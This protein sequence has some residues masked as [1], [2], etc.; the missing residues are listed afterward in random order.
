MS[1]PV[2]VKVH[3][4]TPNYILINSGLDITPDFGGASFFGPNVNKAPVAVHLLV[5]N[6]TTKVYDEQEPE[7]V[8]TATIDLA[9]HDLTPTPHKVGVYTTD[10]FGNVSE[11]I[12]KTITP[13]FETLLDKSKFYTYHLASDATIGYGWEFRYFFDGNTGEPGWHTVSSPRSIGTFGL[14]VSAKISR[15]MVWQRGP[16]Y[17][18]YQNTKDFTIWGSTKDAPADV[19]LPLGTSEGTVAGDWVNM[20][21]FSFPNPPSG[22]PAN[23]ANAAD[24]EFVSKGVNF[25][26]PRI[27]PA[28]KFIRYEC[29]RTWGGL[30]YVNALEISLYGDPR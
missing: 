15:F 10:R 4:K 17:Y 12:Y 8:S 18:T 28:V 20:G 19:N 11:T 1:D 23:Q 16:G 30:D 21:N 5:Y 24:N 29:R 3:P 9:I 14:G 25:R 27:A 13:L 6:E 26:M 2:V 22:L 7:Y